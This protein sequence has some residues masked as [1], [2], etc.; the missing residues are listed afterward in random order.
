VF[1]ELGKF[2][3]K[4]IVAYS[5]IST[6]LMTMFMSYGVPPPEPLTA[7]PISSKALLAYVNQYANTTVASPAWAFVAGVVTFNLVMSAVAGIPVLFLKLGN[8]VGYPPIAIGLTMLG[9]IMQ[10]AG[11]YYALTLLGLVRKD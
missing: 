5:I 2:A 7:V 11:I 8:F 3:F 6:I 4:F 1:Y 9:A 10:A